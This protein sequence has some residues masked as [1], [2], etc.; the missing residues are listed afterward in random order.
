MIQNSQFGW[1]W[2]LEAP[3]GEDLA[4]SGQYYVRLPQV[5]SLLQSLAI[6]AIF[7]NI[8][9]VNVIALKIKTE[10]KFV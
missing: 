8:V 4:T 6:A 5:R 9:N 1:G 2:R 10:F 7:F 3:P